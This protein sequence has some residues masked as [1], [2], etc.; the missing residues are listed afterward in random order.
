MGNPLAGYVGT[1]FVAASFVCTMAGDDRLVRTAARPPPATP[2]GFGQ[3]ARPIV[4]PVRWL[5]VGTRGRARTAFGQPVAGLA[6]RRPVRRQPNDRT[7]RHRHAGRDARPPVQHR[8]HAGRRPVPAGTS[9]TSACSASAMLG[10]LLGSSLL[11]VLVCWELVGFCSYLLIGFWYEKRQA[12]QRGHQG[13]RR[14]PRR[15]TWGCSSR[16]GVL[17]SPGSGTST[18]PHAV[19]AARPGVHGSGRDV[20]LNHGGG[21]SHGRVADRRRA[22]ACSSPRRSPR[23]RSS[24]STSGSP[25]PWRGRRRSR[26]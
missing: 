21:V 2:W 23:A 5:P 19:D 26:P 11:H 18:L 17:M 12:S 15:P 9:P 10:L 25:T 6:R 7:V 20:P 14:Q 16:I 3:G 13:V 8:L 4:M 1:A 22:S 24:R